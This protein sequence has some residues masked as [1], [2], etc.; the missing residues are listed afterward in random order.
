MKRI[1]I[2]KISVDSGQILII[3]PSYIFRESVRNE[4]DGG[5]DIP[6]AHARTGM[7]SPTRW[8]QLGKGWGRSVISHTRTGDGIYPV[9]AIL[10]DDDNLERIEVDFLDRPG[11]GD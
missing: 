4:I 7:Y 5:S 8:T 11:A 6:G 10:D 1:Q 9:T 2:G 3:D